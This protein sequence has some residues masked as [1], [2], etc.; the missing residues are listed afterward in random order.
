MG[1]RESGVGSLR[2]AAA[3]A[4]AVGAPRFQHCEAAC[5]RPTSTPPRSG[6]YEIQINS[7]RLGTAR[8]APEISVATDHVLYQ[9]HDAT[10]LLKQGANDIAALVGDGWYVVIL[11]L[12]Q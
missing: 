11:R 2:S 5:A 3:A 4:G 8:L 9:C 12:E 6:A 1:A 7:Q 10:P